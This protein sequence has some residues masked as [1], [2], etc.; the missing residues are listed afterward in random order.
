MSANTEISNR[1][2]LEIL[3][4]C[5]NCYD[6][7]KRIQFQSRACLN[8]RRHL[9]LHFTFFF[10]F[11]S[12]CLSRDKVGGLSSGCPPYSIQAFDL[13]ISLGR[14]WKGELDL[15]N[16]FFYEQF[17]IMGLQMYQFFIYLRSVIYEWKKYLT[18]QHLLQIISLKKLQYFETVLQNNLNLFKY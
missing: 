17:M 3:K 9:F 13:H 11:F 4:P 15:M 1:F 5:P 6:L 8:L 16:E 7:I 2:N 12:F 10:F 18:T 14:Q